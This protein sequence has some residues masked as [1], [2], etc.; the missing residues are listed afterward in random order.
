MRL[1][2]WMTASIL[3]SIRHREYLYK[4]AQRYIDIP[5]YMIEYKNYRN[6]LKISIREVKNQFYVQLFQKYSGNP[7]KLG[8]L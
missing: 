8:N 6:L 3:Q 1:K 5:F 7:K 4:G 2:P